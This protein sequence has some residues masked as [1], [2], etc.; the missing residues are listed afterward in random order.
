M[1]ETVNDLD[2]LIDQVE[3]IKDHHSVVSVSE[4]AEENR[5]LPP[6]STSMP[7]YYSFSVSPYIREI[8]DCMSLS[9]PVR[10]VSVEKGVQIGM[11]VGLLENTILYC[12]AHVK[13]APVMS[14]IA[15]ETMAKLRMSQFVMP[16]LVASGFDHL[17]QSNEGEKGARK[18][19]KTQDKVSFAGGGSLYTFGA[20]S[21]AKLSSFPIQYLLIDEPDRYKTSL[22]LNGD[23]IALAIG[24]TK[25]YAQSRK[26]CL[27]STPTIEGQSK[28]HD[29]YMDGDQRRY[30]VPCKK[31]NH[32]QTLE[33]NKV[34]KDTGEV[35]GLTFNHE[36]GVLIE[37]SVRYIC[38]N[39]GCE[40]I[41]ADK[42]RMLL[43]GKW[44]PTAKPKVKNERSY[45]ISGLYSP[46]GFMS[47]EDIVNDWFKCWDVSAG[48][49]KKV[50]KLQEFYNNNLGIP[51]RAEND[52]LKF[53]TVSAH[54]R[55]EYR[56]G[57]IPNHLSLRACDDE[58]LLLLCTVDV[59]KT[60]LS[61]GVIGWTSN[62]RPF[63]IDYQEFKGDCED[64]NSQ[65]W[66]DLRRLIG[67]KEYV[68]DNGSR[69]RIA[70]TG[71][72]SGY[73]QHVVIEFCE[74][75]DN[76][77]AMKGLPGAQK[78][79]S[80]AQFK[81]STTSLGTVA[82]N[83][84]TDLYKE[85]WYGALKRT[86]QE[87]EKQHEYCFNV[88]VDMTDKQLKELTVETKVA[89]IDPITKSVR[90]FKWHRPSGA[91]NELWDILGYSNAVLDILAHDLFVE[92]GGQDNVNWV[93]F[94]EFCRTG[95][96]GDPYYYIK[97]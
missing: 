96:G 95:S 11:T 64:I 17:I 34:N 76:T 28:I 58:I 94:W 5:Y 37:G 18:S 29:H 30:F 8:V 78:G 21:P 39:C 59:Q 88:P 87:T 12:I 44:V 80:F 51:F 49:V 85:R 19:G 14:L 48:K 72:D 26:I 89:D 93:Q 57:E 9:S 84:N 54:R 55:K 61:V 97:G 27:L 63:V 1:I 43:K 40:H 70:L 13:T 60:Y 90:G 3:G 6:G 56:L 31:C 47:W 81:K 50:E 83:L 32:M 15:D 42:R 69:Y 16:M 92:N 35:Y 24:R 10:K 67:N 20:N 65:P 7:G 33:W 45:H 66:V 46:V 41:N 52:K 74:N 86:W 79:A 91:N 68:A 75:T 2:W 25:A 4:F 73:L 71:I 23:P 38:S 82:Y 22:K 62:H 36:D 53:T 77:I